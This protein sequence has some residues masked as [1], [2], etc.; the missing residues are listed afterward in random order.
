MAAR[1]CR[2]GY[3]MFSLQSDDG[4]VAGVAISGQVRQEDISTGAG[5][6]QRQTDDAFGT[7]RRS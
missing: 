2:W 1:R 7:G 6:D 5:C 3:P 4:E